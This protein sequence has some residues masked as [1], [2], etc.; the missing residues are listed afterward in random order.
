MNSALSRED[1]LARL[2]SRF[3]ID[4]GLSSLLN[5]EQNELLDSPSRGGHGRGRGKWTIYDSKAVIDAAVAYNF[6]HG[7]F[8]G[9]QVLELFDGK[10][11]RLSLRWV[12]ILRSAFVSVMTQTHWPPTLDHWNAT[13]LLAPNDM[14]E[15]AIHEAKVKSM[16]KRK[17]NMHYIHLTP[18]DDLLVA[19]LH[20]WIAEYYDLREK[21]EMSMAKGANE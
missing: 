6:L 2:Q 20:T 4:L 3:G 7:R 16:V 5:Y 18:V 12:V 13:K 14:C 15:K 10:M 11:P 19:F 9:E 17:Q 21:I 1:L 8:G